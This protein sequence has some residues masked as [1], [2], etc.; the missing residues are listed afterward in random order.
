VVYV[1]GSRMRLE[2]AT[3]AQKLDRDR[4]VY[5]AWGQRL[6]V[7]GFITRE[8]TLRAHRWSREAM[9]TWLLVSSSGA[10][11]SS[12]E[13]FRMES[14]VH[15][16]AD[17]AGA[18]APSPSVGSSYAIASVFTE[19]PLRGQGH[20]ARMMSLLVGRLRELDPSAHASVLY[21]D[22]GPA[23]YERSGYVAM[24]AKDRVL[25]PA[26]GDPSEG[27]EPIREAD[28]ERAMSLFPR[29]S[30]GLV[31]WPTAAQIDWHVERERIY[32]SLLHRA[33]PD[34]CGARAG[35]S[36]ILWASSF[37]ADELWVLLLHG[38]SPSELRLILRSARRTARR[39]GLSR[40]VLW[41]SAIG[42]EWPDGPDGGALHDRDG[43]LPMICPLGPSISPAGWT[44]IPRALWV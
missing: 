44:V 17:D 5:E 27:V 20:A 42:F 24:P 39:A 6:T 29:P 23:I 21:S 19:P 4:L 34:A 22:V 18:P 26:D 40:V 7:E 1:E 37:K 38:A 35:K 28:V 13:T 32:S 43:S 31:I 8:M 14:F 3:D 12:C 30:S 41:E 25:D 2:L 10:I 11:L 36:A 9:R 33:R 16:R 15:R